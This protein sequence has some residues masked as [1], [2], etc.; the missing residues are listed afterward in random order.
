MESKLQGDS[1]KIS[2]ELKDSTDEASHSRAITLEF[3]DSEAK[4]TLIKYLKQIEM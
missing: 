4:T 1:N 2:F 3:P